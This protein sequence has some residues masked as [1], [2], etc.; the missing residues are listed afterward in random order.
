MQAEL[1]VGIDASAARNGMVVQGDVRRLLHRHRQVRSDEIRVHAEGKNGQSVL[2][3][4]AF[5]LPTAS[6]AQ[7][8][9]SEEQSGGARQLHKNNAD[10]IATNNA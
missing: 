5:L 7:P 1:E 2:N 8:S 3:P 10:I 9:R 4:G 6:T